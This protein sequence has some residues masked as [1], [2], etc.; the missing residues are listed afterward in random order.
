MVTI[1]I[2]IPARIT[3]T[4]MEKNRK[5]ILAQRLNQAIK[6]QSNDLPPFRRR[7]LHPFGLSTR[8]AIHVVLINVV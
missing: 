5:M 7:F 2:I 1:L 8:T 4:R 3:R 6:I